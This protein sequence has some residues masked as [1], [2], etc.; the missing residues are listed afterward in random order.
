M[1]VGLI[2]RMLERAV[3]RDGVVVNTTG[4]VVSGRFARDASEFAVEG[5]TQ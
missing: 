2:G 3:E 1:N 4:R 5:A